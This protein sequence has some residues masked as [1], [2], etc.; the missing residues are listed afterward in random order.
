MPL[1]KGGNRKVFDS[2]ADNLLI[3]LLN[4]MSNTPFSVYDYFTLIIDME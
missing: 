1:T 4:E 2:M 3:R